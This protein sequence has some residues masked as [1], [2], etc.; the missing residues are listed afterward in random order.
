MESSEAEG[1]LQRCQQGD[2]KALAAFIKL[3]Q[4][5]VFQFARRVS[6]DAALAEE[7]TAECF[8]RVWK[9]CRQKRSE[10]SLEGWI[11]RI[12]HRTVLDLVRGRRRWWQR[13]LT[14]ARASEHDS[15][16]TPLDQLIETEQQLRIE[17]QLRR[18]IDALKEEDRALI[19]LHYFEQCSLAEIA[20]ILDTSRDALKMKISRIRKRLAQR[21][22]STHAQ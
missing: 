20:V 13:M 21:L 14:G 11:F 12:A 2:E 17:D 4:G 1:L 7:A 10:G 16:P 8:Y 15:Q 3:Y 9:H 6:G 19:H 22:D 5:R 18:A